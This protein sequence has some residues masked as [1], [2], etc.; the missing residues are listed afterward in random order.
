MNS[1]HK[2]DMILESLS[3]LNQA[4][5]ERALTFIRNLQR[6]SQDEKAKENLKREAM[7]EIRLALGKDRMLKPFF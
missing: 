1:F 4:Q 5:A 2:K 7:K 3:S 6:Y